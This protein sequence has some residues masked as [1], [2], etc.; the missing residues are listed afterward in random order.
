MVDRQR[1]DEALAEHQRADQRRLQRRRELQPRR[2][3]IRAGPRVDE[4]TPVPRDPARQPLAAVHRDLLD[5]VGV[6]ARREPAAQRVALLVVEEQRR[7]RERHQVAQLGRDQR[8][9]VGDAEARAE[10]L[11]DLVE[12]VDL[13]VRERDVLEHVLLVRRL[14]REPG[15][16]LSGLRQVVRDRPPHRLLERRRFLLQRRAGA[17]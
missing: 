13:A 5:D 2:F 9:G 10:R 1:A 15:R 6:D 16:R 7:A 8:H 14:R 11:R 3:E 12:R 17:R 4:R